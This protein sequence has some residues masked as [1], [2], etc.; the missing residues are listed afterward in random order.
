MPLPGK[1][2]PHIYFVLLTQCILTEDGD[3]N[4]NHLNHRPWLP[5]TQSFLCLLL[6]SVYD[7]VHCPVKIVI[8]RR[9]LVLQALP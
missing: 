5:F 3:L 9:A 8:E 2:H 4:N 6:Q 7:H 1:K